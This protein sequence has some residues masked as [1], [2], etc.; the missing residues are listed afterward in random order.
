MKFLF[1]VYGKSLIFP[2]TYFFNAETNEEAHKQFHQKLTEENGKNYLI[3][4]DL[5]FIWEV[6]T[7]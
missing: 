7:S 4:N 3:S 2:R 6:V 1:V 5:D